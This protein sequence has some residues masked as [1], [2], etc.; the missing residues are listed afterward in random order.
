M[1]KTGKNKL[2][3]N[4]RTVYTYSN[5]L[6]RGQSGDETT[7]TTTLTGFIAAQK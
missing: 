3:F 4:T 1:K 6:L 2:K 5:P 7:T